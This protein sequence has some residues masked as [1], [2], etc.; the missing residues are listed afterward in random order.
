MS[1]RK[2]IDKEKEV[3]VAL[4]AAAAAAQTA[5]LDLGEGAGFIENVEV[6]IETPALASLVDDKDLDIHVEHSADGE[7]W[8]DLPEVAAVKLTGAGGA[9]VA[10][11]KASFRLP[12]STLR[13][14]RAD[15]AVETG[16]GDN[17]ASSG[18]LRLLF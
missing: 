17:T 9:G 6:E 16:G 8:A 18:I 13:Y 14:I 2:I 15:F 5:A 7:T 12:S 3:T 11:N 4:P 10:A 1:K